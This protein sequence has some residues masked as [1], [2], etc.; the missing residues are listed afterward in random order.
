[1]IARHAGSTMPFG[2]SQQPTPQRVRGGSGGC[3][4]F[5]PVK[6]W[7][8]RGELP[9]NCAGRGCPVPKRRQPGRE[10]TSARPSGIDLHE[11]RT[12]RGRQRAAA[13]ATGPEGSADRD[14]S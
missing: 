1:M 5:S 3:R 9:V 12:G 4:P 6:G 8:A 14:R 7:R 11:L 2:R 13:R 10:S